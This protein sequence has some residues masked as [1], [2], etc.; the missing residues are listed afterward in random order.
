MVKSPPTPSPAPLTLEQEEQR[1]R[2]KKMDAETDL[3]IQQLSQR[4]QRYEWLKVIA[5]FGGLIT[6]VAAVFG[7]LLSASQWLESAE[8]TRR[9]RVEERLDR[10]LTL[11]GGESP[12]TRLAAVV[13]LSSFLKEDKEHAPQVLQALTN[14]LAIEE[15]LT[16]RNAI[17]AAIE[18]LEPPDTSAAELSHAL[19]SLVLVSRGLTQEGDLWTSR[20]SSVYV[21]PNHATVESRALSVATAIA[22]LLHKG[23]RSADMSRI[24]LSAVDLSGL[25]LAGI[26]LDDSILAWTDFS[27]AELKNTSFKDADLEGVLFKNA[28]LTKADFSVSLD[29]LTAKRRFNYVRIQ[30][31]RSESLRHAASAESLWISGPD[32]SC[33]DLG[34]ANFSGHPLLPIYSNDLKAVVRAHIS[35][36]DADITGANFS[37]L[38]GFGIVPVGQQVVGQPFPT[39]SSDSAWGSQDYYA[40]TELVL[41]SDAPLAPGP[42]YSQSLNELTSIFSGSNW[43]GATFDRSVREALNV[44]KVYHSAR[45]SPCHTSK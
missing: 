36:R 39:I 23:A 14:A 6:A 32:F 7:L 38:R 29:I 15:S 20:R 40:V 43:R 30:M 26:K 3:V 13:S 19:D 11:M 21:T 17:I 44:L 33:A 2:I 28:H 18:R 31:D 41:N 4:H 24:Y 45:L 42:N 9:L 10:S 25:N 34:G 35:F 27:H 8:S 5:G 1:A 16:V 37:Q 12:A 22:G